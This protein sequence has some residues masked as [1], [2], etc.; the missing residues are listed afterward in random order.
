MHMIRASEI[1][2]NAGTGGATATARATAPATAPATGIAA[3]GAASVV[4]VPLADLKLQ[5]EQLKGEILPA[6]AEVA[7]S[8]AYVLGP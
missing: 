2:T 3:P 8:T 6:L 1:A 4:N 7:Q 5:Y